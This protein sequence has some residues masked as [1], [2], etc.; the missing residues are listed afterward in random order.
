MKEDN[1]KN[2]PNYI[3]PEWVKLLSYI[4]LFGIALWMIS[5][6]IFP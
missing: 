4:I 3:E 1:E 2:N 5:S 6:F